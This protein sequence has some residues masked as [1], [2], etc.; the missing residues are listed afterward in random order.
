MER[1]LR[2]LSRRND[3]VNTHLRYMDAGLFTIEDAVIKI[4]E[5]QEKEIQTLRGIASSKTPKFYVGV[6]KQ[7][8]VLEVKN[9]LEKSGKNE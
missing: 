4:I 8:H 7:E 2:I 9:K 5:A 3:T 6:T 1:K